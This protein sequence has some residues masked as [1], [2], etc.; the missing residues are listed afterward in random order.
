MQSNDRAPVVEGNEFRVYYEIIN[1]G[2]GLAKNIEI[3][4]RYDPSRLVNV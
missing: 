3:F 2:E 4:D 1:N